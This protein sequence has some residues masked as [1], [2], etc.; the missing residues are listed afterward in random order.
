MDG[1]RWGLGC[2]ASRSRAVRSLTVRWIASYAVAGIVFGL[3]DFVWLSRLGRGIYEQRLGSMLADSPNMIAALM[4]YAVY[5]VGITYFAVLPSLDADSI[6]KAAVAGA[7]LGLV[8][9]ATWNLTNLAVVRDWPASLTPID[10]AWGTLATCATSVVTTL[11][12]RA[13][14]W[15]A[16][17]PRAVGGER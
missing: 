9:Y 6:G 10:M 15:A 8:A 5:L 3:L 17:R 1:L 12:V 14:P 2:G 11:I 13:T 7:L 4:F 16:Q